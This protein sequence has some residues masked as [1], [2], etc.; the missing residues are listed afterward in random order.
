LK[1]M[2]K[3]YGRKE[4]LRQRYERIKERKKGGKE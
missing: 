1:G 2:G 4:G 3:E